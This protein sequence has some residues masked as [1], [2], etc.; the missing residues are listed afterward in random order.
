MLYRAII[1]YLIRKIDNRKE[2][3]LNIQVTWA[4]LMSTVISTEI[5]KMKYTRRSIIIDR[6][7]NIL[8]LFAY[9]MVSNNSDVT[10]DEAS[11][12][13]VLKKIT[14]FGLFTIK[15]QGM[16]DQMW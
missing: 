7:I 3:K 5:T 2:G 12:F 15:R 8:S 16:P 1:L 13:Y 10:I 14:V 4:L 6:L 11:N 9:K